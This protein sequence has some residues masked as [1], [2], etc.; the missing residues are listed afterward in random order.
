MKVDIELTA[1]LTYG[2]LFNI[3][4]CVQRL[5]ARNNRT[6]DITGNLT[7]ISQSRSLSIGL[8]I[9]LPDE[10][11]EVRCERVDREQTYDDRWI[12]Q[13]IERPGLEGTD[14]CHK[15]LTLQIMAVGCPVSHFVSLVSMIGGVSDG[16][17]ETKNPT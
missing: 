2:L 15:F 11:S 12:S 10:R 7:S 9:R 16:G 4:S 6:Q 13:A 5:P 14:G 17:S 1:G 8:N 3:V